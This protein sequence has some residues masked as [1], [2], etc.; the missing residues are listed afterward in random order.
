MTLRSVAA[1]TSSSVV[2][3]SAT[4]FA[5]RR[6]PV[7]AAIS[8]KKSPV[9]HRGQRAVGA[10]LLGRPGDDRAAEDEVRGVAGVALLDDRR[11]RVG[12]PGPWPWR[13]SSRAAIPRAGPGPAGGPASRS[14]SSIVAG[15]TVAGPATGGRGPEQLDRPPPLGRRPAEA[16]AGAGSAPPRRGGSSDGEHDQHPDVDDVG[17]AGDRHADQEQ[18]VARHEERRE[19][20]AAELAR[21]VPLEDER[22]GDRGRR[23]EKPE[24]VTS[25]IAIQMFV[26]SPYRTPT[27]PI[28]READH[29][30]GALGQPLD[31]LRHQQAAEDEA[32]RR[33]AL[34]EPVLELGA[35]EG[36]DGERQQQDVPQAEREEDRARR[37]SAS[38]AGSA[39]GRAGRDARLEVGDD[40]AGR[41]SPPRRP[42]GAIFGRTTT[43]AA[44]KRNVSAS[45]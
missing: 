22:P 30:P 8:P 21:R 15:R 44:E 26:A 29:H 35:A 36:L 38:S 16:R 6:L 11:A 33:Q 25:T 13:R 41:S 42:I 10:V 27:M 12:P 3:S 4:T 18:H 37:R 9:A 2:G 1:G 5:V 23:L 39:S 19:D 34:L 17:E 20:P 28:D 14:K 43:Q 45:T 32:D 31:V 24:I 7:S 40:D